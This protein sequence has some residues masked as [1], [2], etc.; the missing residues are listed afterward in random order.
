MSPV[1]FIEEKMTN[2]EY[3]SEVFEKVIDN[4][5]SAKMWIIYLVLT[6]TTILVWHGKI[7]GGDFTTINTT[8]ITVVAAM[9]EVF[10]IEQVKAMAVVE[11]GKLKD[12]SI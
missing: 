1:E 4:L 9:R 5:I 2:K 7:S 3:W 6:V 10:K 12:I 11:D 8:L